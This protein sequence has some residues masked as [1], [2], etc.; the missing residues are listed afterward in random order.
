MH[1]R[2]PDVTVDGSE[3]TVHDPDEKEPV[4][5]TLH[6]KPFTITMGYTA[7]KKD[8]KKIIILD[9]SR[10]EEIVLS[11]AISVAINKHR[12]ICALH[13]SG[14]SEIQSDQILY[15]TKVAAEKVAKIQEIVES[16]I[17]NDNKMRK[18]RKFAANNVFIA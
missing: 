4:K 14:E 10:Q 8:D 11:G 15:C 7:D 13:L 1:F 6:H 3:V 5:L 18:K 17:K 12:E 9:P 2:R 16:A